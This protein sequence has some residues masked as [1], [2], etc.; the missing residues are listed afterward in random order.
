MIATRKQRSQ[1]SGEKHSP[2][3][4]VLPGLESEVV[5]G[6]PE[7]GHAEQA[8]L[9]VLEQQTGEGESASLSQPILMSHLC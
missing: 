6:L 5:D 9:V 7:E 8:A 4:L 1:W 2:A 3:L